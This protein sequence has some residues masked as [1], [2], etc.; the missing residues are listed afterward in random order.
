MCFGDWGKKD[1][2]DDDFIVMALNPKGK[3]KRNESVINVDDSEDEN[4]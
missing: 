4:V 2:I 1:F 3:G